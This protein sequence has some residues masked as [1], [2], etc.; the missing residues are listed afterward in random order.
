MNAHEFVAK[1]RASRANERQGSQEHFIDLCRLLGENTPNDDPGARDVYEFEHGAPRFGGGGGFADVWFDGHFGWEYKGKRKDLQAAYKQLLDYH[2]ALGQPPLLVV[3][4][5]ERFEVHTKWI[6][7]ESWIYHFSLDDLLTTEPVAVR[8]PTGQPVTAAPRITAIRLL[9]DLFEDVDALRPERTTDAVTRQAVELFKP[10]TDALKR[11]TTPDGRERLYDDM[12]IARFVIRMVFCMFATDIGLLPHDT[13]STILAKN[14]TNP[15][16]CIARLQALWMSMRTGGVFDDDDIPYFNG[17]L[18]DDDDV[19]GSL[20]TD[21]IRK[22]RALRVDSSKRP[23][24]YRN[25]RVDVAAGD[26][27]D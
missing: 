5:L 7:R 11:W 24:S 14:E 12:R 23:E 1:W 6:N 18:F 10:V 2:E 16:R 17:E 26:M 22:L 27:A 9:K 25:S 4:D 15:E 8:T 13:F 19:P 21:D 20:T 3:C